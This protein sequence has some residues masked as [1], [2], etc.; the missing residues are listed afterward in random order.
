MKFDVVII[1]GGWA[2]RSV[3][4]RLALAGMKVCI[5]SE[6]LSL[7]VAGNNAPYSYLA[8]LQ[9]RGVTVLRGDRA[10][11]GIITGSKATGVIT[12]NLGKDTVLKADAFVLATGKFFSR[13][14]LSDMNHI[15][16]PVFGADVSYDADR[17]KWAESEFFVHQPFMDFGVLTDGAGHVLAGGESV[18]NLY[19]A[20]EILSAGSKEFDIDSFIEEY[21]HRIG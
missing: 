3:A 9:Q 12:R 10:I 18:V 19:A 21:E 7:A 4:D 1:G 15:W 13:G 20:G 6:G 2:G 8:A 5:V 16:E 14:L 17:T 11:K